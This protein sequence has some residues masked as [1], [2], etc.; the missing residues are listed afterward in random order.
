M[1]C[2]GGGRGLAEAGQACVDG[3][4]QIVDADR[5]GEVVV[6]AEVHARSHIGAVAARGEKDEGNA[7]G[8][9]IGAQLSEHGE[10]IE[11]GHHEIAQDQ[12][13]GFAPGGIEA[14]LPPEDRDGRTPFT[15]GW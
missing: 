13:R 10:S 6:R 12:I 7:G 9:G 2:A 5:F 14:R 8:R 11:S 4:K 3:G 1:R 15:G